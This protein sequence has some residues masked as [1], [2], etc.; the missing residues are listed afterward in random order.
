MS[1][2]IPPFGGGVATKFKNLVRQK[3]W[4]YLRYNI[5]RIYH[6]SGEI[7]ASKLINL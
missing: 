7:W 4:L 3:K 1:T 2:G 6:I 5:N